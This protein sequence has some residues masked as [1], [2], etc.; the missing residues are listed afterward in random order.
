MNVN[1]DEQEWEE[2]KRMVGDN[3]NN[4][5]YYVYVRRWCNETH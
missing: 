4:K 2:G 5:V 3:N 1:G